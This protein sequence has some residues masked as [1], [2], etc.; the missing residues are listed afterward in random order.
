MNNAV[1]H[2]GADPE[3]MIAAPE[4]IDLQML[5]TWPKA[6]RMAGSSGSPAPSRIGRRASTAE[7]GPFSMTAAAISIAA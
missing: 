6:S 7:N 4:E 2:V 5:R 1:A 3:R